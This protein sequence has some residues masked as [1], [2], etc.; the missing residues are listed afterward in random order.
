MASDYYPSL[1]VSQTNVNDCSLKLPLWQIHELICIR[2]SE[3]CAKLL[4]S[5][6]AE[7]PKPDK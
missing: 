3:T 7:L 1:I 5:L 2:L 4:I 6:T